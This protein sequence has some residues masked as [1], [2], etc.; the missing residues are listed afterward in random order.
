MID[1][2]GLGSNGMRWCKTILDTERKRAGTAICGT[3]IRYDM[4]CS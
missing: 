4:K 2:G 1:D 3:Q